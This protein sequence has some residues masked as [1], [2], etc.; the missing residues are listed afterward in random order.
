MTAKQYFDSLPE[1]DSNEA[2]IL[3]GLSV[4]DIYLTADNH[5]AFPGGLLK[6]VV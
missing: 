2:A 1:Y 3:G 5:V 6:L 4:G